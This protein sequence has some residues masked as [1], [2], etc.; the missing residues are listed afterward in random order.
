MPLKRYPRGKSSPA[1]PP[2]TSATAPRRPLTSKRRTP[3][4]TPKAP[5][6][7]PNAAP[8]R[9]P[10]PGFPIVGIGASAGGL[11]ALRELFAAM[12]PNTGMAFVVI[13]HQH[14]GTPSMLPELLSKET[15]MPVLEASDGLKVLPNHLYVAAAGGHIALHNGV[16]RRVATGAAEAPHLPIDFFF[17]ALAADQKELA[18]CIILSGTG[19]DGTLGLVA[20]KGES[21][22]VMVEQPLSAKYAG[23]PSSAIASGLADYVLPPADMPKRL[24][25]YARGPYLSTSPLLRESPPVPPE[26]MQRIFGLLRARTGHDFSAYKSNTIRRRIE[27]RMNVHQIKKPNDYVRYLQENP[28]EVNVLFK[29]LLITVTCFFRDPRAW[30]S[31]AEP[32]ERLLLARPDNAALRIWVPGCATGEEVFSLAILLREIIEKAKHPCETRIFGTDLDAAAIEAARAGLYPEG[33]AG[34]VHP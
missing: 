4:A 27:R 31:L 5:A 3:S 14:P 18:I 21:G 9:P 29:E 30:E 23:M 33:I 20:I 7:T 22:M 17:R 26:P 34:D 1:R 25:A 15:R 6:K 2:K 32:L 10:S 13:T 8:P 28:H 24:V 16:L 19:T 11:E 12:P